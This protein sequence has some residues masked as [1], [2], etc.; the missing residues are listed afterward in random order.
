MRVSVDLRA[1]AGDTARLIVRGAAA[2]GLDPA[3]LRSVPADHRSIAEAVELA[4]GRV[5]ARL[6]D[7]L[8]GTGSGNATWSVVLNRTPWMR[9]YDPGFIRDMLRRMLARTAAALLTVDT[10]LSARAQGWLA[11]ADR[12]GEA[13]DS[14]LHALATVPPPGRVRRPLNPF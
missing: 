10:P 3:Q 14:L 7:H 13:L 8:A 5:A 1:V 2:A 11:D 4:R 9:R 12:E 6:G